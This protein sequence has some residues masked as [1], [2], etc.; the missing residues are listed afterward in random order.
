[1]S[2]SEEVQNVF[3]EDRLSVGE[4]KRLG[5]DNA[6]SFD[7]ASVSDVPQSVSRHGSRDLLADMP[8][9]GPGRQSV[10]RSSLKKKKKG[11]QDQSPTPAP[12]ASAVSVPSAVVVEHRPS[13]VPST[14]GSTAADDDAFAMQ[15]LSDQVDEYYYGVRIFPGQDPANVWVGWVTPQFHSHAHSFNQAEAVRKCRYADVD[16]HGMPADR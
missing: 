13:M 12:T 15:Q 8:S 11:K 7:S 3:R 16:H 4:G 10:R 14:T 9:S 5:L 1:M 6:R 2:T